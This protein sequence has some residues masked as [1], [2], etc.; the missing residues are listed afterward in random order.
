MGFEYLAGE[1]CFSAE[2]GLA[3]EFLNQCL[4]QQIPLKRVQ[5]NALGFS[6]CIAPRKYKKLR[7]I[8]KKHGCKIRV[9]EKKGAPFKLNKF[10]KRYGLL[11]GLA[12]FLFAVWYNS[13]LVWSVQ[14]YNMNS[15]QSTLLAQKL[16]AMGVVPGAR[17]SD[18]YLQNCEEKMLFQSPW[19]GWV[20]L[21]FV[22]G[23]LIVEAKAVAPTP[24]I[25]TTEIS[26]I[27]AEDAGEIVR[28]EVYDGTAVKKVGD[29]V[30]AGEA[31]V[32]G[33][34]TT[35][36]SI[37]YDFTMPQH[38][39]AAVW[40]RVKREY[41][42]EMPLETQAFLPLGERA[43]YKKYNVFGFEFTLGELP[44]DNLHI[45]SDSTQHIK[46]FGLSLPASCHTISSIELTSETLS[47]SETSAS[48][49]CYWLAS[50]KAYDDFASGNI[51][52]KTQQWRCEDG[53]FYYT[54]TVTGVRDIAVSEPAYYPPG[55]GQEEK[56]EK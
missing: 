41:T 3:E 35:R 5:A 31:I 23:N 33:L 52:Y 7:R 38:S 30:Q 1:V 40:A 26:R 44:G 18:E 49:R 53:V 12:F 34:F 25:D 24:E 6:A 11:A 29:T 17:V 36:Y 42:F 54:L 55:W 50:R 47:L 2:G 43:E 13:S 20:S 15:L 32:E 14:Y 45:V 19:L 10:K 21:N 4:E 28:M 37:M 27:I 9:Q 46:L 22:H 48:A 56:A 8:A 51:E 16:N 39:A